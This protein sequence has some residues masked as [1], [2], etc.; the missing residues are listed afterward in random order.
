MFMSCT[1]SNH[2]AHNPPHHITQYWVFQSSHVYRRRTFPR[3]SSSTWLFVY[4][5]VE[6][7]HK[8]KMITCV[9]H[10]QTETLKGTGSPC[11]YIFY[12]VEDGPL[13]WHRI[14][15]KRVFFDNL[16]HFNFIKIRFNFFSYHSHQWWFLIVGLLA[17][18]VYG[19]HRRGC[20]RKSSM[21][22]VDMARICRG[23]L[24][25]GNLQGHTP[26][27]LHCVPSRATSRPTA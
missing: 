11:H 8:S 23:R 7:T 14:R 9:T 13:C 27:V 21:R 18:S 5:H 15:V 17:K 1:I 26:W 4:V 25:I 19:K 2:V 6:W 20:L 22:S 16:V 3:L 12:L 10:S 24:S